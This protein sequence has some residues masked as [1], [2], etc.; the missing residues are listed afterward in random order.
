MKKNKYFFNMD[1]RNRQI[2][3]KLMAVM[4]LLTIISIQ[5]VVIYRQFVLGQRRINKELNE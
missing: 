5:G 4:Y 3:Y 2:A 1:E